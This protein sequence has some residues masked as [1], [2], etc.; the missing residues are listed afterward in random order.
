MQV[1]QRCPDPHEL[2]RPALDGAPDPIVIADPGRLLE[3][4]EDPGRFGGTDLGAGPTEGVTD[5]SQAIELL[6]LER[7]VEGSQLQ[8]GIVDVEPGQLLHEVPVSSGGLLQ[9]AQ[10]Q[11]SGVPC[12]RRRHAY[13]LVP[14]LPGGG[15][16]RHAY[17]PGFYGFVAWDASE[18]AQ[19]RPGSL[20]RAFGPGSGRR[21][22]TRPGLGIRQAT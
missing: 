16:P 7:V 11:G 9:D 8:V 5:A 19:R 13:S 14:V 4:A 6:V 10:V 15:S 3:L 21:R 20:Q 18:P 1:R 17:E 2:G 12:V 22:N